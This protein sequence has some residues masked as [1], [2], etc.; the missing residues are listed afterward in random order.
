[1]ERIQPDGYWAKV[2]SSLICKRLFKI[3]KK[4]GDKYQFG[5]SPGVGCQDGIFTINTLLHTWHNQNLPSYAAFVDLVEAFDTINHDMMLKV[6]KRYGVP[7]KLRSAISR[8]YRDLKIVLKIGKIEYKMS[9][10]VGVRQGECMAPVIFLFMVTEFSKTLEKECIRADLNMVN[11]RQHTHS[12]CNV[13]KL[14][15]QNKKRFDQGT[16]LTI[17]CVLYI[18]DN[19]FT[20]EYRNQLTRGLTLIYHHFTRFGIEMHVGKGKKASKNEYFFFP[21]PVFFGRKLNLPAKNSG[22]N[23]RTLVPTTRKES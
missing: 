21:T 23:R 12:P 9:Q 17:F 2:F 16:L 4:H 22:G 11:L 3:I 5:T 14:T 1:M 20:F 8:M 6:L 15:G 13:G 19:A 18:D 7:P 10:T